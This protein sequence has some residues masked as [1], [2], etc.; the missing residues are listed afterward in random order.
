MAKR[1]IVRS[2]GDTPR[3]G[4]IGLGLMGGPMTLNLLKKGLDVTVWNRTRSKILPA[5]KLGAHEAKNA[6]AVARAAD[7]I[8]LCVFDTAAVEDVL[9]GRDG[10]CAGGAPGKI[11]VDHSTIAPDGARQIAERLKREHGMRLVDAPVTG[12]V[13]GAV[14]GTLAIFAGGEARDV[15][16]ARPGVEAM[17]RRFVRMGPSGA[18]QTTKMCNQM[19]VAITMPA[20]AEMLA[21]ARDNGV[22]VTKLPDVLQGGFADSTMLQLHGRRMI[23][24]DFGK[25][26]QTRT[27][28]KDLDLI[29][30]TA[31]ASGTATPVTGL[32]RELWR[33]HLA[34]E[35]AD[36]DSVSIAMLHDRK[37]PAKRLRA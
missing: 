23:A 3:L 2:G 5:L 11:V 30:A 4:F 14:A 15:E 6:A 16:S 7:I 27:I 36:R 26:G 32:V 17:A 33:Y 13:V 34:R 37:A 35:G 9:F 29:A 8:H 19:M 24:R 25:Q 1:K 22:D 21:L 31:R 18:G 20:L 28:V 12:G 10:V